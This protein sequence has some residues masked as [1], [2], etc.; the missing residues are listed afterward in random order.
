[1]SATLAQLESSVVLIH[2]LYA[3]NTPKSS[4]QARD[5]AHAF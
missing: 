5:V 4:V 1:M 3:E 2:V